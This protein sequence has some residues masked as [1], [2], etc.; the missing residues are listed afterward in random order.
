MLAGLEADIAGEDWKNAAIQANNLGELTL[1]LGDVPRALDAAWQ[2]VELADRSGDAFMRIVARTKVADALHQAGRLA[3]AEAAFREA[4][5][6][7]KAHQKEFPLLYSLRGFHYCDLLLSQG[8]VTEVQS[9]VAK[10]FEWRQ[11]GDSLLD[12]AFENLSLGRAY[13]LQA[14]IGTHRDASLHNAATYLDHAV[15]GL[16][17]ASDQS[18]LPVGL[19]ARAELQRVTGELDKAEDDLRE[20]FSIATRGEMRLHVADCHLAYARLHLA[21][22]EK[23]KAREGLAKAKH[24][25]EQ[26]GYH[27]RDQEVAELEGQV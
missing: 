27:R 26:T 8:K 1:T 5:E 2:S 25:I 9:R 19:L 3:Q 6:M 21:R 17:Q 13:L 22:G 4:E 23:D 14:Q 10:F 16:R 20:A 18:R 12:I 15:D 24:I 7:Q 11:P